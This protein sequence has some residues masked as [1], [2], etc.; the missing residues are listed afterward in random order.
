[1]GLEAFF[2]S[3][4]EKQKFNEGLALYECIIYQCPI[5]RCKARRNS[6]TF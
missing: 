1:M 6:V 3:I 2:P 5:I 4:K